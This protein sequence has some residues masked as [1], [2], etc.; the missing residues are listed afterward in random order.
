[1][2]RRAG[3]GGQAEAPAEAGPDALARCVPMAGDGPAAGDATVA[4]PLGDCAVRLGFG[5]QINIRPLRHADCLDQAADDGAPIC[6]SRVCC[7][8][9]LRSS[10]CGTTLAIKGLITPPWAVPVW[11]WSRV[12]PVH[13]PARS[14]P[15][16]SFI[17][18]RSLI[19]S[20]NAERSTSRGIESKKLAMS[21]STTQVLPPLTP[22]RIASNACCADR[23]GRKP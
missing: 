6:P 23:F 4:A 8:R 10:W 11:G 15:I 3:A 12:S 13:T 20:A 1:M 21:A 17:I 16:S 2:V 14:H 22:T 7:W 5:E 9:H 18:R 19:R